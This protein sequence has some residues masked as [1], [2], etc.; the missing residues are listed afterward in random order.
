MNFPVQFKYDFE[1]FCDKNNHGKK[2]KLLTNYS[3]VICSFRNKIN[4]F[5]K[6]IEIIGQTHPLIRFLK[7]K[8]LK[9]GIKNYPASAIT[10][11]GENKGEYLILA[12]LISAKGVTNYA[13]IIYSGM[14]IHSGSF[15]N[16][17]EA[18]HLFLEAINKG[19]YWAERKM[20]NYEDLAEKCLDISVENNTLY[21]QE[22]M[23]IEN[24]N[25]DRA[26]IQKNALLQ[27]LEQ[28]ENVFNNVIQNLK[29]S[30]K[31]EVKIK[32]AIKMQEGKYKKLKESIDER[33]Y[34]IEE[35]KNLNHEKQDICLIL[36]K[37]I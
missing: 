30:G 21:E 10:L 17:D 1:D 23:H 29:L 33:L 13:K 25:F 14:D 32:Q 36:L 24:K 18:E 11:S 37:V 20:L 15:L 2:N 22:I 26:E 19:R 8:Q 35:S 5:S 31:E 9:S 27:H 12:T 4:T 7:E 16:S 3:N 28:R 34:K 6:N